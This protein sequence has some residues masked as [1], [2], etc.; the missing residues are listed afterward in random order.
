M[1]TKA[2]YVCEECGKM[3]LDALCKEEVTDESQ[4]EIPIDPEA[5]QFGEWVVTTLR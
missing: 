2:H 3:F 4:I 5:H 1:G